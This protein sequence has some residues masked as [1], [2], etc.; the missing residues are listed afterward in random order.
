MTD[1]PF[2]IGQEVQHKA[3]NTKMIYIGMDDLGQAI[4]T[5]MSGVDK[6]KDTFHPAELM[7]YKPRSP[8]I[9]V[10]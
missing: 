9:F 4:C 1:S 7:P 2:E 5:W 8:G 6:R 3:G 10:V